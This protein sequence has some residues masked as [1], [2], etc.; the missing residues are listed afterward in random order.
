MENNKKKKSDKKKIAWDERNMLCHIFTYIFIIFVIF[1][2]IVLGL[3]YV[4]S[5]LYEGQ[6][7]NEMQ[8]SLRQEKSYHI[9]GILNSTIT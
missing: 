6:I 4:S 3:L 2:T 8:D 1:A 7:N 9:S 5:D